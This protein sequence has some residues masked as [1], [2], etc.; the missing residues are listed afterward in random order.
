[1]QS[2][3]LQAQLQP[4]TRMQAQALAEPD[5]D[6]QLALGEERQEGI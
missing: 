6:N 5:W 2:I 1:M 3:G 4:S